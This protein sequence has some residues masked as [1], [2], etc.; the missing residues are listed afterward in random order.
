MAVVIMDH[1][2][3]KIIRL[4]LANA[5]RHGEDSITCLGHILS[6]EDAEAVLAH[7]KRTEQENNQ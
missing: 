7:F 6:V 5:A 2:K 1:A 4:N 3:A